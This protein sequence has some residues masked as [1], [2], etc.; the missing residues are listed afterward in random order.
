MLDCTLHKIVNIHHTNPIEIKTHTHAH[1]E[2]TY[3]VSGE[4]SIRMH[5][6]TVPYKS[7]TFAFFKA[8]TLHSENDPM[9]CNI[10]WLH[11]D[12]AIDGIALEEGVYEDMDKTLLLILK[13]LK[14]VF[15]SQGPYH[16]KLTES[17]LAEAI[18][19]SA[20]KQS[21][22]EHL[23]SE[24][25]WETVTDYI[26]NNIGKPVDFQ[27]LAFEYGYS[28]DRFRHIFK[29]AFG[30]SLYAYL[31]RQRI[32]L[33]KELL[34]R[35]NLSITDVAFECGFT[36]SSQFANIFKAHTQKTPKAYRYAHKT[37]F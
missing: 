25:D 1:D 29:E 24:I 22:R 6:A 11:F 2:I 31:T 37:E 35:T 5:G 26:D 32:Q 34:K 19:A 21:E 4:G 30:I 16:G 20:A 14:N 36:S 10:I 18:I 9:P 33:S 7:N 8:G 28:Y 27:A 15:C 17:I 13:K 12:Y 3:F 23:K